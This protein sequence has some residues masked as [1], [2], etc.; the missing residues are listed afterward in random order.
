MRLLS[1]LVEDL[2]ILASI[3]EDPNSMRHASFP[4]PPVPPAIRV[5]VGALAFHFIVSPLACIHTLCFEK[6]NSESVLDVVVPLA[7]VA[8]SIRTLHPTHAVP[9]PFQ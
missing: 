5:E 9:L 7:V 4:R 8:A 6:L 3:G 1:V 2:L